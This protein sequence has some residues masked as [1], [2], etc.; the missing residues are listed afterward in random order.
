[1]YSIFLIFRSIEK[2]KTS[3]VKF[4]SFL[5]RQDENVHS[6]GLFIL[7]VL[8]NLKSVLKKLFKRF[9]KLAI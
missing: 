9:Y 3:R 5:P 7:F 1:M 8:T 2:R 4:K 6:I